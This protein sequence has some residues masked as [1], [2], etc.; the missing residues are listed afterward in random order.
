VIGAVADTAAVVRFRTSTLRGRQRR[1]A[2]IGLGVVVLV[3]GGAAVLPA[4]LPDG[5]PSRNDLA[6]LIPSFCLGVVVL[7]TVAAA[8]SGGG[9]QLLPHDEG[10]AYPLGPA[11][12]H[13]GALVLAPL[14][15]AWLLQATTLLGVVAYAFGPTPALVPIQAI[16][17]LWLLTATTI[18]QALSWAIEW[19]RRGPGGRWVVRALTLAGGGLL[20]WLAWSG[21]LGH[22]LDRSRLTKW[23]LVAQLDA[24]QHRWQHWAI[25]VAALIALTTIALAAGVLMA[26]RVAARMPRDQIRLES[27]YHRARR[28]QRS[29]LGAM[30]RMDHASVWR[31]VPLRRGVLTLG[32][33]PGAVALAGDMTWPSVAL[34]PGLVCSGAALLFGINAWCLDGRGALWRESLPVAATSVFGAR[35][36]VLLELLVVAL[37]PALLLAS[38][39]AGR[40][41]RGEAAAIGCA[42]VVAVV[43]VLA[44][45]LH[46]SVRSPYAADLGDARATPAPPL[47]MLVHSARLAGSTTL[48]GLVFH[49]TAHAPAGWSLLVALPLVLLSCWRIARVH[50]AWLDPVVRSRVLSTVMG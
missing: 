37:L 49:A 43:H 38:L 20:A 5:D 23:L 25:A 47:T 18:A 31:S 46:W 19:V 39:R 16:T 3:V 36:L 7:A 14:N 50:T 4:W 13:L 6:V 1:I 33:L 17:L 12:D 22:A 11:V 34:L 45:C 2:R 30:L 29:D 26:G 27:A 32:V 9:R 41:T 35:A 42:T 24:N 44:S 8:T 21:R 15:I 10:I 40:P 48:L 28:M